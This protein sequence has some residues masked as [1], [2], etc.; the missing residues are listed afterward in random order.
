MNVQFIY[1][2]HNVALNVGYLKRYVG[3]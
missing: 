3:L 1:F 2:L